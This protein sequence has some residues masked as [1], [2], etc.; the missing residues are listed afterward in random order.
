MG[1]IYYKNKN[2]SNQDG[3]S[4]YANNSYSLSDNLI[5]KIYYKGK[6]C[7]NFKGNSL[8]APPTATKYL[9]GYRM[10]SS[11]NNPNNC[12]TYLE[13]AVGKT[14]AAM[15]FSTGEFNYG[16]WESAFFMP[17]PCMLNYDGTVAYYLDPTNYAYKED[18][19]TPSDVDNIDFPGNAMME[20]GRDGQRI[21]YKIVPDTNNANSANVY[22]ANYKA[23]EDFEAW[24]F[25]DVNGNLGE[26]FYSAIYHP[27]KDTDGRIRSISGT[28]T[29]T[30]ALY[31]DPD[32]DVETYNYWT[33]YEEK[34]TAIQLNNSEDKDDWYIESYADYILVN[35]LTV[36]ITKSND[37]QAKVGRG[38]INTWGN[39]DGKV[40]FHIT[41]QLDDKGLFYGTSSWGGVK[42]FGIENYYGYQSHMIGGYRNYNYN[43]YYKLTRS[44]KDGSSCADFVYDTPT[45]YLQGPAYPR[46]SNWGKNIVNMTFTKYGFF[47]TSIDYV[48]NGRYA[49]DNMDIDKPEGPDGI[50][51]TRCG[52]N[53]SNP[54]QVGIFETQTKPQ[55]NLSKSG[56]L[57]WAFIMTCKPEVQI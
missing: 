1:K 47:P 8:L 16:S 23:D 54:E 27:S 6:D 20:W 56:S 4:Y 10:D 26:H 14:P 19:V 46:S 21:W 55:N 43:Y 45:D 37:T 35:I 44:T 22:I 25:Y 11:V 30:Y 51:L 41:G 49:G 29:N 2:Y 40:D 3:K 57:N 18:G 28:D 32:K 24:S 33:S 36:L 31:T 17:R 53:S 39:G 52:W 50:I 13:D 7:G 5:S 48:S 9:Y 15:N 38:C 12:I 34:I 42:V